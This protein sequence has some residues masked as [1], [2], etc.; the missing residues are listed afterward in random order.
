[1]LLRSL[2]GKILTHLMTDHE[3]H[4]EALALDAAAVQLAARRAGLD[5]ANAEGL[6]K[7]VVRGGATAAGATAARGNVDV[8][9]WARNLAAGELVQPQDVIW[10]KAA[11]APADAPADPDA[12]IGLA[13]KRALRAGA[14]VAGRD[15][16]AAQVIK[17]GEIV[18]ITYQDGGISLSLQGKAMTAAG[19]HWTVNHTVLRCYVMITRFPAR[20]NEI[21]PFV[22][23]RHS[24]TKV[25]ERVIVPFGT[26][27]S[28][29]HSEGCMLAEQDAIFAL[30]KE[31]GRHL[32]TQNGH[33][34]LFVASPQR[35]FDG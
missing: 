30:V 15:V 29:T 12:V 16:A 7:I 3:S 31:D 21:A 27:T 4:P 33:I 25:V 20:N 2:T 18:T 23:G 28:L 10:A 8:L 6:R 32:E 17:Q 34:R 1:M 5:W 19:A 24:H 26:T 14:S 22:T 9:T 35:P 11:A 13:A